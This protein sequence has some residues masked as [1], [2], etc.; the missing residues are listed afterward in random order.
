[1]AIYSM[2]GYGRGQ[3]AARG[4]RA[5]VELK[6]VNHKQFDCRLEL[7]PELAMLEADVRD[8][9]HAAVARG[10]VLC[11][12]QVESSAGGRRRAAVVDGAV[13]RA[14]LA[15]ARRMARR[16]GLRDDL[17][18]G[19][20]LGLPRVVRYEDGGHNLRTCRALVGR[21]LRRALRALRAMQG[22]EGAALARDLLARL[23]TLRALAGRIARRAPEVARTYQAALR[24][25]IAAAGLDLESGDPR[26]LKEVAL[27]A[28]RADV[29]EELTRLGSHLGQCRTLIATGKFDRGEPEGRAG[30]TLDF[31][32]QE[33]FREINTLGA[34]AN[35]GPIAAAVVRFK[36]ELERIREQAQNI[37]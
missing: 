30:R 11:R 24:R 29:G 33:L 26:L 6:T 4:T 28:D 16:L 27:F 5:V 35:D 34:K 3:A 2:T 7:P 10:H 36:T 12:I 18:A 14:Y 22:R 17:T 19:S 32:I 31:L 21:A 8:Q 15:G 1:M 9:I 37:A 20:L 13:A 25:R 23:K